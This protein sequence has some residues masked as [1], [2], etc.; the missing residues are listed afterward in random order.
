MYAHI[1]LPGSQQFEKFGPASKGEC[2]EWLEQRKREH[3]HRHGGVWTGTYFPA[4]IIT[5]AVAATWRY[6]DGSKVFGS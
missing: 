6:R 1:N 2:L 3:Q 5:N 4:A